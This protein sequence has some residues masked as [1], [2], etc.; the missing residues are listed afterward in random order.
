MCWSAP[1]S[2]D[3]VFGDPEQKDF[4]KIQVRN[5]DELCAMALR[6]MFLFYCKNKFILK[7]VKNIYSRRSKTCFCNK[8]QLGVDNNKN[9]IVEKTKLN[10]CHQILNDFL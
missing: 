7:N 8:L 9:K 5:A 4:D 2:I 10:F 3:K 1:V 6:K